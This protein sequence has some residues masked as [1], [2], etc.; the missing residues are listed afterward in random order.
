MQHEA[1]NKRMH[2]SDKDKGAPAC[3]RLWLASF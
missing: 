2:E 3:N 1:I